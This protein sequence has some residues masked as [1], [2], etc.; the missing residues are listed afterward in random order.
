MQY[1]LFA[2]IHANQDALT[3]CLLDYVLEF[4]PSAKTRDKI[5]GALKRQDIPTEEIDSAEIGTGIEK[6]VFL[7]DQVG[8]GIEPNSCVGIT[9]DLA[10]EIILGNHDVSVC[11]R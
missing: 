11:D 10:D 6:I 8:Y 3:A 7:G 2:D 5:I 1:F 9:F 4:E